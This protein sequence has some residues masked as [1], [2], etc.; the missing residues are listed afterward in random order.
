MS[1]DQPKDAINKAL[2]SRLVINTPLAYSNFVN[3]HHINILPKGMYEA[4]GTGRW[5][6]YKGGGTGQLDQDQD[7]RGTRSSTNVKDT[8]KGRRLQVQEGNSE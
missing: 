7:T 8:L 5:G 3:R 1:D 6:A 2:L 4:G